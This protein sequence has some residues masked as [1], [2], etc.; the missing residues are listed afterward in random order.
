MWR[1]I[2]AA[3]HRVHET[4]MIF[5]TSP[6]NCSFLFSL[7]LKVCALSYLAFLTSIKMLLMG[8]FP[9]AESWS[10]SIVCWAIAS[11]WYLI[12]IFVF[13][14]SLFSLGIT[15]MQSY[16]RSY[17][18]YLLFQLLHAAI[19]HWQW[20]IKGCVLEHLLEIDAIARLFIVLSQIDCILELSHFASHIDEHECFSE[21]LDAQRS[22]TKVTCRLFSIRS[23]N[24]N[25]CISINTCLW[26]E[27]GNVYLW[28]HEKHRARW[29]KEDNLAISLQ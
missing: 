17:S 21:H 15:Q 7:I 19:L 23:C 27:L 20:L 25:S 24:T 13:Y 26:N 29:D 5:A 11:I 8:S 6:C 22:H 18:L 9:N 3:S 12:F 2:L 28:F 14:L 1:T 16:Q 10:H 4:T